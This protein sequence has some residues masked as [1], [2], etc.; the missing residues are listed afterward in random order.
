MDDVTKIKFYLSVLFLLLLANVY[1]WQFILSADGNLK[2]VFFD[3]GEGDAIFFQTPQGHQI[4]IDGGPGERI[5][6]KLGQRMPFWDRSIDLVVL[7][8]PEYDHL[9]GLNTV[10]ARYKVEN[11]IWNGIQKDSQVFKDWQQ[12]LEKEKTKVVIAQKGQTVRAGDFRMFI[13]S[14]KQNL[15]NKFFETESNDTSVVTKIL[16]GASSFLLTGDIGRKGEQ[17]LMSE[18]LC[19]NSNFCEQ[20]PSQLLKVAHHGSKTSTEKEFLAQVKPEWA[21]ISAGRNNKYGHPHQEV[22]SNLQEFG[23]KIL[24]TDEL[25]DILITSDGSNF[26][27]K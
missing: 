23:I 5:L 12:A 1:V 17:N 8:H 27:Y 20:L 16:F 24:R 25:G 2:A 7:T 18:D 11:I 10:L 13:L 15:Q 14:P 26:I 21:V 22:L 9:S 4:L 19:L 3:V 6:E